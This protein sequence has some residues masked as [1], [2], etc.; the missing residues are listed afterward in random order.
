M[1]PPNL[2]T[3]HKFTT[4]NEFNLTGMYNYDSNKVVTWCYNKTLKAFTT[5]QNLPFDVY[6]N[7]CNYVFKNF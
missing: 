2:Q 4:C 1:N 5:R 7:L 6:T 3:V